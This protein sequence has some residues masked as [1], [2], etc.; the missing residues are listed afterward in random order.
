VINHTNT[1]FHSSLQM[2]ENPDLV[3]DFFGMCARF[4]RYNNQVFYASS[5]LENLVKLLFSGIKVNSSSNAAKHHSAFFTELLKNLRQQLQEV[6]P[7]II[8]KG[9][10]YSNSNLIG[11]SE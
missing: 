1:F 9:L 4:L 6:D 8:I 11:I 5:Q 3:A 10:E 7:D 2:E